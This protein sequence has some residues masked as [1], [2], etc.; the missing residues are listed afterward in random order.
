MI[1][2]VQDRERYCRSPDSHLR[3]NAFNP[4]YAEIHW[5]G[6]YGVTQILGI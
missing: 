3:A 1:E 4:E 6:S 5:E 2:L